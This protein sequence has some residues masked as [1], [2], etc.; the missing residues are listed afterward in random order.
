M[1]VEHRGVDGRDVFEDLAAGEAAEFFD[2][3]GGRE[4]PGPGDLFFIDGDVFGEE[5]GVHPQ[6]E[7]DEGVGVVVAELDAV[8]FVAADGE[9]DFGRDL[10]GFGEGPVA[11]GLEV[12]DGVVGGPGVEAE[13]LR[14]LF[15][16]EFRAGVF[17]LLVGE[18]EPDEDFLVDVADG[19]ERRVGRADGLAEAADV[20]AVPEQ[21][22]EGV[23]SVTPGPPRLLE[24]GLERVG[25]VEVADE[26][27]VGLV[28]AHAEGIGR[29]DD[30]RLAALPRVLDAG[31]RLA[32]QAGVVAFGAFALGAQEGRQV[33]RA[34]AA[35][36]VDDAA[37][38][39]A[40][41]DFQQAAHLV[42]GLAE[43]VRQVRPGEVAGQEVRLFEAEF[44][45]DVGRDL[46]R[47]GGRQGH[48]R[49]GGAEELPNGSDLE[50][51]GPEVVAPLRN[52]VGLVDRQQAHVHLEETDPKQLCPKPFRRD[53]KELVVAV[54]GVV[55]R[56][57]NLPPRHPRVHRQ[58]PDPP[59]PKV[60]DLVFHQRDQRRHDD[61]DPLPH[62]R[63]HLETHRLP[64]PRR[65][66]RQHI[67]P[68]QRLGDNLLLH[69]P[70]TLVSPVF[71]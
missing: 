50:V 29:H 65:Q 43:D 54:D 14:E 44:V 13:A 1:E 60:L 9:L 33:F 18:A 12:F 53:V 2:H 71:L 6:E 3:D 63:R 64:S 52:A 45:H 27:H 8:E 42:V 23:L 10:E 32:R 58:R 20:G 17:P 66:H 68:G 31:A 5:A 7:F 56:V 16:F 19:L 24:V 69:R 4:A 37:A 40:P 21:D 59:V 35:R 49:H 62:Q 25:H 30:A 36:H 55:E 61:A 26:A 39:H 11:G 22:G 48:H 46:R 34:L 47:G 51:V 41:A 28:D 38:F 70:E 57:I 15:E 67:P